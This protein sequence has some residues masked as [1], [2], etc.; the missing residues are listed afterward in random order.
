M[1]DIIPAILAKDQ[2]TFF[3]RL[4]IIEKLAPLVQIDVMDG[5]FVPDRSWCDLD[6]LK[7]LA[8]PTSFELHLMVDDPEE[9]IRRFVEILSIKRL[10][11][12]VEAMGDHRELLRLCRSLDRES[13]LAIS[14]KTPINS[15][16]PYIGRLDEIL[17]L[18]VEPGMSGQKL[19]PET[20]EKAQQIS[21][22]WPDILL[23]FD[24]GVDLANIKDLKQAGVTRFCVASAIFGAENTETALQK[25]QNI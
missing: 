25:M 3:D 2:Q 15:L 24:G 21:S 8:T 19:I 20:V 7:T 18:G 12:H 9:Y 5:K 4:R 11:W 1:N 6:V 23:A 10:I 14:P 17:V 22:R 16:I 13:G